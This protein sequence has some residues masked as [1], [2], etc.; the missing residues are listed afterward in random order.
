MLFEGIWKTN[1]VLQV[2]LSIG[3]LQV[4]YF[5]DAPADHP[6]V[7]LIETSRD[8]QG[9]ESGSSTEDVPSL[10]LPLV[11]ATSPVQGGLDAPA[12]EVSRHARIIHSTIFFSY[13]ELLICFNPFHEAQKLQDFCQQIWRLL[14]RR[15]K[16]QR[17][18]LPIRTSG[19]PRHYCTLLRHS[20]RTFSIFF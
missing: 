5:S 9:P 17:T 13:S 8:T 11:D 12:A 19:K 3:L 4:L 20:Q 14:Q 15:V 16:V 2:G 7:A 18:C 10:V 6:R 1:L